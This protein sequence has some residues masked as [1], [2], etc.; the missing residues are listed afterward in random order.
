MT[1][2]DEALAGAYL[3]RLPQIAGERIPSQIQQ[4]RLGRLAAAGLN[5]PGA[6]IHSINWDFRTPRGAIVPR[7]RISLSQPNFLIPG[8]DTLE[9]QSAV[10]TAPSGIEGLEWNMDARAR[11]GG[12]LRDIIGVNLGGDTSALLGVD[13]DLEQQEA[14]VQEWLDAAD[15]NQEGCMNV[16][17]YTDLYK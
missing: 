2:Y 8:H 16:V 5:V 4:M 13:L 17:A 9:Q 3:D 12:K 15:N 11:A 10:I 14:R 1:T 6:R 7:A